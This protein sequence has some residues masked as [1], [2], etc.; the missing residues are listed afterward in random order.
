MG[1][2]RLFHIGCLVAGLTAFAATSLSAAEDEAVYDGGQLTIGGRAGEAGYTQSFVDML[3]PILQLDNG[4]LFVNPRGTLGEDSRDEVNLGLGYRHLIPDSKLILGGNIYYDSHWSSNNNRFDQLGF[5]L[6]AL[7]EWIDARINYYL[8]ESDTKSTGSSAVMWSD[9]YA[10]ENSIFQESYGLVERAR[11][12]YDAEIGVKLPYLDRWAEVRTFVGYHEFQSEFSGGHDLSGWK[13]RLEVRVAPALTLDAEIFENDKI[14][15]TDY[16]VGARVSVPFNLGNIFAGRNP[17]EGAVQAFS[18]KPERT[19]NGRLNEMVIRDQYIRMEEDFGGPGTQVEVADDVMFVDNQFGNSDGSAEDPY[20]EIQTAVDEASSKGMSNVYVNATDKI[21]EENVDLP[22]GMNIWGSIPLNGGK[23]YGPDTP[24]E[25]PVVDGASNGPTITLATGS[26]VHGFQV[27][28]SGTGSGVTTHSVL[29]ED[30]TRFGIL[31]VNVTDSI[32]SKNLIEDTTTGIRIFTDNVTD[33]NIDIENN[34]V[35]N[36]DE[37]GLRIDTEGA[38]GTFQATISDSSFNNNQGTSEFGQEKA[39]V[40][41]FSTGFDSAR[42]DFSDVTAN[43]NAELGIGVVLN[44]AGEDGSTTITSTRT[45]ANFNGKTGMGFSATTQ[46]A[47]N[48]TFVKLEDITANNNTDAGIGWVK[49]GSGISFTIQATVVS[50]TGKATITLDNVQT[51]SNGN[52]GVGFNNYR[53]AIYAETYGDNNPAE[54]N[55]T[56]SYFNENDGNGAGL[57]RAQAHGNSTA[58]VNFNTV[59]ANGNEMSG[60]SSIRADSSEGAATVALDGVQASMNEKGGGIGGADTYYGPRIAAAYPSTGI[61]ATAY[62]GNG[63]AD[64]IITNSA[65]NRNGKTGIERVNARSDCGNAAVSL[66]SVNA[67]E[68]EG[69]GFGTIRS[70]SYNAASNITLNDVEASDN[71]GAGVGEERVRFNI[72]RKAPS[73]ISAYANGKSNPAEIS[74]TNSGFNRNGRSGIEGL[75]AHSRGANGNAAINLE[76]VTANENDGDGFRSIH[77]YS[78]DGASNITFKDVEA[79]SNGREGSNLSDGIGNVEAR[80]NNGSTSINADNVITNFNSGNG[81]AMAASVSTQD[82]NGGDAGISYTD[83]EAISN[84]GSGAYIYTRSYTGTASVFAQHNTAANNGTEG[85]I[86]KASPDSADTAVDFGG[87]TLGSVGENSLY[88]NGNFDFVNSGGGDVYI[89][90][91]WWGSNNDPVANGQTDGLVNAAQWLSEKPE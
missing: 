62:G 89:Q 17:F 44:T 25:L 50:D 59:T 19:F 11:E 63:P 67:N 2:K 10:E 40:R 75:N 91:S 36:N 16:Y 21:Y 46:G 27:K 37:S 48:D 84:D 43:S 83:S 39:G 33:V 28:N 45:Q 52:N 6:E 73:S 34:V 35:R 47:G 70:D 87:G 20:D 14:H 85:I 53:N 12:G 82:E 90:N 4:V 56:N 15:G 88:G 69:S 86:V 31:G 60:L 32:I 81:I 22:E 30:T 54:I 7:S 78:Y 79:G 26:G 5:G 23:V 29:G 1:K 18:R 61:F 49:A 76:S 74:I 77:T 68:N 41:V 51:H 9:P 42:V 65:F 38:G 8:P 13:G 57:I 66:A 64:I 58:L 71:G 24:S 55:I 80:S 3:Y 72:L